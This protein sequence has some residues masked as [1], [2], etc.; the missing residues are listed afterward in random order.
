MASSILGSWPDQICSHVRY[1][2]RPYRWTTCSSRQIKDLCLLQLLWLPAVRSSQG[3]RGNARLSWTSSYG[4]RSWSSS[5]GGLHVMVQNHI[6]K[7]VTPQRSCARV[8]RRIKR[9]HIHLQ[10]QQGKPKH[11]PVTSSDA[12][13]IGL[14]KEKPVTPCSLLSHIMADISTETM[15]DLMTLL[16]SRCN[17]HRIWAT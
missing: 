11:Q 6:P 12:N 14:F 10:T 17:Q 1:H 13:G 3:R 4:A 8:V 16:S 15:T 2:G 9:L 7:T 5:C